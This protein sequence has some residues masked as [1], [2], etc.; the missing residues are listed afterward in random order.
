MEKKYQ[1]VCH[2]LVEPEEVKPLTYEQALQDKQQLD[3]TKP[4]NIYRMEEIDEAE[5]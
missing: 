3:L 4:E 1:L 2:M 5:T